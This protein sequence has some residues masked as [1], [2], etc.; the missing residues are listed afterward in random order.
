[1]YCVVVWFVRED[2]GTVSMQLICLLVTSAHCI[3][4]FLF[5]YRIFNLPPAPFSLVMAYLPAPR[6]WKHTLVRLS[7]RVTMSPQIAARDIS[8]VLDEMFTDMGLV[9]GADQS[10]HLVRIAGSAQVGLP[11]T[12]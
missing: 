10:Y 2:M 4:L 6:L 1:M 7:R 8:V 5:S 12:S 3:M 9:R 11:S